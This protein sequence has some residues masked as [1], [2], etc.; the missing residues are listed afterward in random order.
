MFIDIKLPNYKLNVIQEG[1]SMLFVIYGGTFELGFISREH[2]KKCGFDIIKK[3]N[4]VKEA[5]DIDRTKYEVPTGVY[6]DWFNDKIY[7]NEAEINKLDFRYEFDSIV[8]GFNK[9]QILSAVQGIQDSAI[10]LSSSSVGFIHQLKKAYGDY[11]T[12]IFLQVGVESIRT[13]IAR[14]PGISEK[15]L[16][17]RFQEYIRTQHVYL[18]NLELFDYCAIYDQT[19]SGFDLEALYKQY[20]HIIK[21]RKSLERILNNRNY[22]ELPYTGREP[23]AFVSYKHEDKEQVYPIL[24]MLQ[25]N[26]IRI[27]YDDGIEGGQNWQLIISQK[28]E[29]SSL[30][31]LFSSKLSVKSENVL[32]EVFVAFHTL[33]K[34]FVTIRLDNAT[35]DH[36]I[37]ARINRHQTINVDD[38]RFESKIVR[39]I[40]SQTPEI[41]SK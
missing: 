20:D 12:T 27:W 13:L 30:F 16:D 39:A 8:L 5:S 25:R 23:Y 1:D 29:N 7:L 36:I 10:T 6:R 3:Y 38:L 19:S 9:S 40:E 31:L 22:V 37:E 41:F 32:D 26:G 18:D 2:L 24:Y 21:V 17:I 33:N 11:V 35:F 28:M 34:K 4:Y 15:E 14:Q